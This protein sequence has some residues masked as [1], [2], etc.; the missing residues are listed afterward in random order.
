M[1]ILFYH[2]P[3]GRSPVENFIE[4]LSWDDQTRFTNVYESVTAYGL[5]C[6]R[7]TFK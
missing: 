1:N 3:S 6:Q 7:V 4:S 5:E 2:T